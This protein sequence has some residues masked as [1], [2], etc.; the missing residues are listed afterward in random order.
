MAAKI[1]NRFANR[2]TTH[3][4]RPRGVSRRAFERVYFPYLPLL[5]IATSMLLIAGQPNPTQQLLH[6]TK[7]VLAYA[8]SM[9][10]AKLLSD[11]NQA[12]QANSLAN[13]NLND[14]LGAAAGAKARDMV[15]RGYFS[16]QAPDG[17]APWQFVGSYGYSY[18]ALGENLATG[19][20]NEDSTV[21]AW[22]ASS[23][24]R[25][26][27]LNGDYRDVGFGFADSPNYQAVGGGPMTVVVA[28]YAKP[29]VDG[30]IQAATAVQ[31]ATAPARASK[32]QVDLSGLPFAKMSTALVSGLL[33]VTLGLWLN[34]HVPLLRRAFARGETAVIRHPLTDICFLM[35]VAALIIW[36]QTAGY[37]H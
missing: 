32:A 25:A 36:L 22:L 13:L 35:V 29:A 31:G 23:S 15:N 37:I 7:T 3:K 26:N 33:F 14:A 16:H 27:I 21:A 2:L 8:T 5:L 19:F 9:Q 18:Q 6:P 34:R 24:H 1:K 10:P 28:Y 17:K 12:R 20:S 4:T 30:A 11:T